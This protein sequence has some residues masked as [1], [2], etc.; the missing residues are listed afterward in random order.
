[1]YTNVLW[2]LLGVGCLI[3]MVSILFS[4]LLTK[5]MMEPV[6]TMAKQLDHVGELSLY[7][8]LQPLS[9]ALWPIRKKQ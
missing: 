9:D 8:E 1:M 5:K 4:I 7:K 2:G 6:E 3:V